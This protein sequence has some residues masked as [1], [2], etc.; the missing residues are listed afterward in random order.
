MLL[1]EQCEKEEAMN[2]RHFA[3]MNFRVVLHL[4]SLLLF[5]L[6]DE[7]ELTAL[8]SKVKEDYLVQLKD[9]PL[10]EFYFLGKITFKIKKIKFDVEH[11]YLFQI[12]FFSL[13]FLNFFIVQFVN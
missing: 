7:E 10:R 12:Y 11:F 8:L 2:H 3:E 13:F 5:F 9:R 6:L 1:Q 4:D